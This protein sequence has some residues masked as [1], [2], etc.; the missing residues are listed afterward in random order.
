MQVKP[1]SPAAPAYAEDSAAGIAE[2]GVGPE[3]D[4]IDAVVEYGTGGRVAVDAVVIVIVVVVVVGMQDSW[5]SAGNP[6]YP[7]D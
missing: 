7:R 4:C 2:T 5:S 1:G 6:S 3:T